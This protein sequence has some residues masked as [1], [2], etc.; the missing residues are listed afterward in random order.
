MQSF[1][2]A[3]VV[4][5]VAALLAA[6]ASPAV[7]AQPRLLPAKKFRMAGDDAGSRSCA[8]RSVTGSAAL[9]RNLTAPSDGYLTVRTSGSSSS[10]WDL[11][12]ADRTTGHLLNGSAS[13]TSTE[14]ATTI[15]RK[16]QALAVQVCRRSGT[17]TAVSVSVQ[18]TAATL[19]SGGYKT[20][21]VRVFAADQASRDKLD[22]LG[23][24]M[25]DHATASYHDVLLHSAAD[26]RKLDASGLSTSVR[27]A[28]LIGH[29]RANLRREV[30]TARA[31]R[32][33]RRKGR[34]AQ[35][36]TV[37]PSGST[38][39]RTLANI[40]KELKDLR[41]AHPTLVRLFEL[42]RRTTE[43]RAIMGIEI[44][45]N[46]GRATDGRPVMIQ[47]GTHHAREWPANESTLEWGY[48]L[49]KNFT[50]DATYN[51][52]YDPTLDRVV[53]ESRSFVIPVM[54]V[55]GFDATI[56][57]EG[58]NPDGSYEDPVDSG[59]EPGRQ[60]SGEQSEGSG[61]YKRKTCTDPDPVLQALPC[62]SRTSYH[63]SPDP[64]D[65][66]SDLPDRGVDPNR[67]Y[68]VEWGG[69][70]TSS[71]VENLT[72]HGPSAWSEPETQAMREFLRDLQ[73]TVLI[74]NHTF[75]GLL[76]RP[77]GTSDFGPVPDEDLLRRLGDV[78]GRETDYI[79]EYSYQLYDTI[80]T[81]DDYIYD[82]L[83][84]FSYTPEIG[85]D[86]FHP[87]YADYVPE[88]DGQFAEDA[89]GNP[90]T[91]K[92]GGLREA[93]TR[94]ARAVIGVAPEDN[95]PAWQI[96]SILQGTAPAGRTLQ[97]E[98]TI[99]YRTSSRPDDDGELNGPDTITEPRRSTLQVPANGQ[100]VWHVN[101]SSQPRS[102]ETTPWR[103]TCRD[104][105][106]T[107]LETR[108]VYVARGQIV[109]L[110]LTCGAST[111]GGGTTTPPVTT[112]CID[113]NG[114]RSVSVTRRGKGLRFS[115]RRKVANKVT[116]DVFQTSKGRRINKQPRRV[117]HFKNRTKGFNWSGK[118]TKKVPVVAGTYY[119]RF[120][121]VDANKK[122]DTRRVVLQRKGGR[123][124]K[125]GK[126][127]Q[128]ARCPSGT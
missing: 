67:N 26:E 97:I 34:I 112:T 120:R 102:G 87:A 1:S 99:S 105:A 109:N 81:T 84:G 49:I 43:G 45:E 119:V 48:E 17:S 4:G 8:V 101:P 59:G 3:L 108:D 70:G 86:E 25:A 38:Q 5:G 93:Y 96:D 7:A 64:T 9:R 65:D 40:Q 31:A 74:T 20:K 36:A 37:L 78:M 50:R 57:S 46:V 42:P 122:V 76:L 22:A 27:I 100:F 124:I 90:T 23:L 62:I 41:D 72:Y 54:N 32:T 51:R 47:V 21:L 117:K 68:G 83:G 11:G 6:S 29:S 128:E 10:D 118:G 88:Y 30:R 75:S 95:A 19:G 35:A 89:N 85:K 92:L 55:D 73:P 14:I 115:F 24:D 56:E 113:P 77:P 103:M 80:G 13:M 61:A 63:A 2:R 126:Y 123:F 16:G 18:F 114:F 104:A 15:V 79:S 116:V 66:P 60:T 106:G 107:V 12:I 94:A 98:K 82:G 44:A 121:I 33:A 53:R 125:R 39:Y 28:D 52:P 71:D 111:T 91:Q 69:P 58:R 127:I 110:G